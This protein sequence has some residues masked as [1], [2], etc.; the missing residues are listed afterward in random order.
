MNRFVNYR[1][2]FL[3]DDAEN[4][5][6]EMQLTVYDIDLE[7]QSYLYECFSSSET[8]SEEVFTQ[9]QMGIEQVSH[10]SIVIRLRP[11]SDQAV[12]NLLNAKE[13]NKLLEL[14]GGIL[15]QAYIKKVTDKTT[16]MSVRIQVIYSN[17]ASK[18]TSEF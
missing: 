3:S 4:E 9:G 11:I 15:K 1:I 6:I 7:L 5:P 8:F 14:I 17:S 16:P 12:Q 2:F 10:G 13:N 18:K